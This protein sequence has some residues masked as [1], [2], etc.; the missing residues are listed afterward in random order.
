MSPVPS[1][2]NA[3]QQL[4]AISA[5]ECAELTQVC[6]K[7]MRKYDTREGINSGKYR[8]LLIEEAGDV[9]CMIELMVEHGLLTNDELSARVNVKR[10]KLE[11]WSNLIG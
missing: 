2:I 10:A 3:I 9:L 4:I 1:P 7:V 8:D 11:T 5:E 6:M